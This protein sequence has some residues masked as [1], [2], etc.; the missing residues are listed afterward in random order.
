MQG[1]RSGITPGYLQSSD[2]FKGLMAATGSFGEGM[3]RLSTRDIQESQFAEE[4]ALKESAFEE[5]KAQND[6]INANARE[7]IGLARAAGARADRASRNGGDKLTPW[8]KELLKEEMYKRGKK[9]GRYKDWS[10][11]T[12]NGNK[13]SGRAPDP[14]SLTKNIVST[15]GVD[16]E[17]AG[18]YV[19][20]LMDVYNKQG[21]TAFNA[22][23]GNIGNDVDYDYILDN[24]FNQDSWFKRGL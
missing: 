4:Q 20:N 17:S 7:R 23:M 12:S 19:S 2:P 1:T 9:I 13:G 22:A 24:E 18:P 6:V 8:Q 14:I 15:Y 5:R 21:S 11:D 3:T 16:I 10:K